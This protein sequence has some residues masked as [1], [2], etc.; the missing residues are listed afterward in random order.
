MG[1]VC[2]ILVSV[3]ALVLY[4]SEWQNEPEI[5]FSLRVFPC[6]D[7][8]TCPGLFKPSVKSK[9]NVGSDRKNGKGDSFEGCICLSVSLYL[10]SYEV[11]VQLQSSYLNPSEG[12]FQGTTWRHFMCPLQSEDVVEKTS[13]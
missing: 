5:E 11:E 4:I 9:I 12:I 8:E 3:K 10:A 2:S 1:L 13:V 7:L 6:A